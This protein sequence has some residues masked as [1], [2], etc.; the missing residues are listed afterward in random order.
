V[1]G[2]VSKGEIK[3]V[4]ESEDGVIRYDIRNDNTGKTTRYQV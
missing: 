1:R 3:E 2:N 4:V